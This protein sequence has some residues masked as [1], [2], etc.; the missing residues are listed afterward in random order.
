VRWRVIF[1][2][3]RSRRLSLLGL[4][5]AYYKIKAM[6]DS[7]REKCDASTSLEWMQGVLEEDE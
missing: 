4:A 5:N 2:K 1:L 3:C 6:V 7:V